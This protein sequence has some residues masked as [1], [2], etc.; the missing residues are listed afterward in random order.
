MMLIL[1][2]TQVL[3]EQLWATTAERMSDCEV[4]ALLMGNSC[5]AAERATD[6]QPHGYHLLSGIKKPT[7][8]KVG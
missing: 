8:E 1:E 7:C 4:Q 3:E 6:E 2:C 5:Q